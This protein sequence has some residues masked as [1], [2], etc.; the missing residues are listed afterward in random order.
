M[1]GVLS[2][3]GALVCSDCDRLCWFNLLAR[4]GRCSCPD[5]LGTSALVSLVVAYLRTWPVWTEGKPTPAGLVPAQLRLAHSHAFAAEGG[6]STVD[7]VEEPQTGQRFALKR[8]LCNG[9]R[10]EQLAV[11]ELKLHREF[12]HDNLLPLIEYDVLPSQERPGSQEVVGL[13]PLYAGG[14]LQERVAELAAGNRHFSEHQLL[15]IFKGVCLG[16]SQFHSHKPVALAHRDVKLGNVLLG[17]NDEPVLMDFGSADNARVEITDRKGA[18]RLQDH[19]AEHC[20]MPYR[21]PELME[22]ATSCMITESTD[23]WSLGCLL[24]AMAYH[25]TPFEMITAYGGSLP[26]AIAQGKVQFP[27]DDPYSQEVRDLILSMLQ[28][29]PE[30]RPTIAELLNR[31]AALSP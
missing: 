29:D 12:D 26:L 14:S 22:V 30:A 9:D 2:C 7:L 27:H 3:E 28:L 20:T 1:D 11:S 6:F 24:F 13:F 10:E 5:T 23:I 25:Q 18:L 31:V 8:I 21:A 16:L 17:P 4:S 15:T 19:A